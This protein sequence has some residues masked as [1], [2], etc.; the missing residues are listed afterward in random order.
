VRTI[1]YVRVSTDEQARS[2]LGLDD[3][4]HRLEQ[5]AAHRGWAPLCLVVDDGYSGSS[6]ERPGIAAALEALAAGEADALVVA[7]L[8]RLSRSLV[9]FVGLTERAER[10][11][12]AL[13]ALDLGVDTT[14]P[15]G[16]MVAN[17]M[18]S[19]AQYERRVIAQRTRDALAALKRRGVR[20]GRP[21]ELDDEIRVR[22][23]ARRQEGATLRE[24]AAELTA[25]GIPTA[26]SGR[27][28]A[29]TVA[30]VV[31]SVELDQEALERAGAV[32]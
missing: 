13:V 27:W 22:I 20:L 29:A 12:W 9:D 23:V 31:R 5:E 16:E 28:H 30:K 8:D 4:R 26:R 11:R 10:E 2:G 6:L 21:V 14:T 3:Q 24:I 1:G 18:A 19:F 15:A 25:D 7:K 32:A 17:V